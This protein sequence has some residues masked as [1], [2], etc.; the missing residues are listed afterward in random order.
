M[1]EHGDPQVSGVTVAKAAVPRRAPLTSSQLPLHWIRC[2]QPAPGSPN[3]G[4]GAQREERGLRPSE[5]PP[6]PHLGPALAQSHPDLP[7]PPS[8]CSGSQWLSSHPTPP[9]HTA[10]STTQFL[11]LSRAGRRPVTTPSSGTAAPAQPCKLISKLILSR[12]LGP[13]SRF[14]SN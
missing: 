9:A 1:L 11:A 13:Q 7:R 14:K 8:L 6:S 5:F 12:A 2:S 4:Q 10:T 3:S